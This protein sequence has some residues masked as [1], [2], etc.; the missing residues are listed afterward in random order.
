MSKETINMYPL[1]NNNNINNNHK[2]IHDVSK[3]DR[4]A[5]EYNTELYNGDNNNNNNISN[6]IP[7]VNNNFTMSSQNSDTQKEMTVYDKMYFEDGYVYEGEI[8]DGQFEGEG[9]LYFP[10]NPNV[11]YS[12]QWHKGFKH[13]KGTESKEDGSLYQGEF[14]NGKRNGKGKLILPGGKKTFEGDFVNGIIEGEGMYVFGNGSFYKGEWE[15]NLFNG[16]GCIFSQESKHIGY[17]VNNKKN[18]YGLEYDY[19]T[20]FILI[21]EWK[22]D[23]LNESFI[24]I[25]YDRKEGLKVMRQINRTLKEYHIEEYT[26]ESQYIEL[27]KFYEEKILTSK[28]KDDNMKLDIIL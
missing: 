11:Y 18:G 15:N 10:L 23:K 5:D 20:K 8:K 2:I 27:K 19:Q 9:K 24:M 1:H 28:Y 17:F 4:T 16:Y 7:E 26:K 12:G 22:Y 21:G 6:S 14:V 25:K 3:D 13:G